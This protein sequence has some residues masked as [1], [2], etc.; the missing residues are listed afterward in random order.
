MAC[1]LPQPDSLLQAAL[2]E[3]PALCDSVRSLPLP[4]SSAGL[5]ARIWWHYAVRAVLLQQRRHHFSWSDLKAA[6]MMR[7]RYVLPRANGSGS[8]S[9]HLTMS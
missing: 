6:A 3:N 5:R 2:L 7:K 8:I 9:A 4:V 1:T